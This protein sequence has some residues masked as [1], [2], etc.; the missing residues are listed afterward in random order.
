[1]K[2]LYAPFILLLILFFNSQ[3]KSQVIFSEHFSGATLTNG[4]AH[5]LS[6]YTTIK[7]DTLAN[8]T[9]SLNA[10]F[11]TPAFAADGWALKMINGDTV[12]VTTAA[13]NPTGY[14][15]R[16][17]ITPVIYGI[18]AD[19]KLMWQHAG[20]SP[21]SR[22]GGIFYEVR[23]TTD[24]SSPV[25]A[26][27]FLASAANLL[28]NGANVDKEG[29]NSK[30]LNLSAYAGLPVR[31][32]YRTKDFGNP[33]LQWQLLLDDITVVNSPGVIDLANDRLFAEP[34]SAAGDSL[35]ISAHLSNLNMPVHGFTWHVSI[36][37]FYVDSVVTSDT[38]ATNQKVFFIHHLKI[39]PAAPGVYEVRSWTS[40]VHSASQSPDFYPQND[41]QVT[42]IRILAFTANKNVLAEEYT[43]AWCGDCPQGGYALDTILPQ[44]PWM[45]PV[46]IHSGDSMTIDGGKPSTSY[47]AGGFPS[48]DV[49]RVNVLEDPF[50]W[51]DLN[52]N[53]WGRNADNRHAHSTP[54]SVSIFNQHYDWAT[55]ELTV[56]VGV[57]FFNDAES[58]FRLNCWLTENNVTG[59]PGDTTDNDWNN[60][61]YNSNNPATP[62]FGMGPYLDPSEYQHQ[63][64]L[65]ATLSDVWGDEG[66]IPDTVYAG[67]TFIH[68]YRFTLPVQAGDARR[69]KPLDISAVAFLSTHDDF[70]HNQ[71][72]VNSGSVKVVTGIAAIANDPSLFVYPNPAGENITLDFFSSANA[73]AQIEIYAVD[74]TLI[75]SLQNNPVIT[76]QNKIVIDLSGMATGAYFVKIMLP[77]NSYTCQLMRL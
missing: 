9:D 11:D 19:S 36:G 67:N 27:P 64:V 54:A 73:S 34:F 42:H 40:S 23:I 71:T 20:Y 51:S 45:I 43:G 41:T 72:I 8:N 68:T 77:D 66:I 28:G 70:V 30:C 4:C 22:D 2:K 15:E 32:A 24:T 61:N 39:P 38:L 44:R 6:V 26:A 12:A 35:E 14:T 13:T 21:Y 18:T 33:P 5:M 75:R 31:I 60:E 37:N 65:T 16:W 47:Y 53:N 50:F 48:V 56:V 49:D 55:R 10:P 7:S 58:D 46:S 57:T 52:W 62:F 25:L 63:H 1:M 17:L 69:W 3:S 29:F 74:G 59:P 76:G